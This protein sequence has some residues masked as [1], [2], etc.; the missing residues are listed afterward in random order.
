MELVEGEALS[1][2]LKQGPLPMREALT[3]AQQIAVALE[4][5]HE[6]GVLHRDL[7]PGNVRLTPEGR[8]KLLDFGLAKALDKARP[9]SQLPTRT[10]SPSGAGLVLGTAPYMSPEQARG[11]ELDHRSDVWAFGCVLYEMLCGRR[12]F[13]G[14]TFSDTVAA[15]LE[16][17]PDWRAV[18][19]QTP[20]AVRRLL[21][22]CLQ[23]EK[24]KRLRDIGDAR[25]EVEEVL[26]GQARESGQGD[27]PIGSGAQGR[28]RRQVLLRS[29][30]LWLFAGMLAA[31]AGLLVLGKPRSVPKGAVVRLA[32][33]LPRPDTVALGSAS[34]VAFSPDGT[35]LAYVA[36]REGQ[37]RIYLRALDQ[38]EATPIPGTEGGDVPFFS[39]DGRWLGF[40]LV[41]ERKLK[42]MPLGG[43]SPL[44]VCGVGLPVGATW[45]SDDTIVFTRD[46]ASGLDRVNAEGGT[47]E[48]LTT[49]DAS[50]RESSHRLPE[51]L[52]GGEAVVFAVKTADTGSYD[53]TH[54]EAVSLRTRQRSVLIKGGSSARYAGGQLV[55]ARAGSLWAAPLDVAR[56]EVT[57]P[58][59]AVLQGVWGPGMWGNADFGLSREG[60]LVYVPG[61]SRGLDRRILRVDRAGKARPLMEARRAFEAL[62]LSPDGRRLALT[63]EGANNQIWVYDLETSTLTPQTLRWNNVNAVW[64]PDGRRL[65][66]TSNQEGP[67][68]LFWQPADGSGPAERLT[69]SPNWQAANSWSPDAK[70]LV[71]TDFSPATR[72]DIW[73]LPLNGERKPRPLLAGPFNEDQPT[74]SP[75]GRWLAYVSDES[76]R[77]EVYVSPFPGAGGRWPVSVDGGSQP[78]WARSGRELFYRNGDRIIAVTV[79]SDASFQATKP[80]LLF[81]SRGLALTGVPDYDITPEGDFLMIQPGASDSPPA[82]INVVLN[83]L[84]EIRPRVAGRVP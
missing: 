12:A 63:I 70:A 65:T 7:K 11:Q 53:D 59:V 44:D 43:G 83:W 29:P 13:A 52:L 71:F 67:S 10:G 24:D 79:T 58:S 66:F 18:P 26:E 55:Y 22:R 16:R 75:S 73:V 25:L 33:P 54:I 48:A 14:A 68:N 81:E 82:Q 40:Y 23:K 15:I 69:T 20:P 1:D 21:H 64:T 74:L 62:R 76:G 39:P 8:V 35:R 36:T 60:A 61:G 19:T 6:K 27:E 56:L 38:L 46:G 84:Q 32:L 45:G 9:D 31:G 49:L 50:R 77:P 3:V 37:S 80:R 57:G 5:A 34:A 17:E 2:R 41:R 42:K 4:A 30:L 78:V 72:S 47:P 51:F 28:P